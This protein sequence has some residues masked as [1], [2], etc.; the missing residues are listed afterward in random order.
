MAPPM[1]QYTSSY[2][3]FP[4]PGQGFQQCTGGNTQ[5]FRIESPELMPQQLDQRFARTE[6]FHPENGAPPAHFG[7]MGSPLGGPCMSPM[8][9]AIYR[10]T[11]HLHPPLA[12]ADW[13][14]RDWWINPKVPKLLAE[15]HF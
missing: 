10:L 15:K 11:N 3:Q 2:Q 6:G 1:S 13:D 5:Q 12:P 14:R 9:A 4:A 8:G 7:G